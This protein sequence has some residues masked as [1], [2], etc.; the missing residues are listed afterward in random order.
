VYSSGKV[1]A[2][3][4]STEGFTGNDAN[5]LSNM[6]NG[7]NAGLVMGAYHLARP[8]NN[9]AIDEA[10]HFL[11]IAGAYV[12]A[13]RLPP[14]LDLEPAYVEWMSQSAL[15]AWVQAWITA[16]QNATGVAP[17]IYTTHYDASNYL[18]SSLN[19]YGLWIANF[20]SNPTTPPTNG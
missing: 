17:V 9:S 5:F 4:K 11:S 16:V 12:G 10:A 15:S 13:G 2:Y 3:V 19:I 1:F 8:D 14:A 6:A 18:N 7:T 20:E